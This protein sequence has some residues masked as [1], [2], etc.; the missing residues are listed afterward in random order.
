[1]SHGRTYLDWNATAPLCK[2]ARDAMLAAL[3][4]VGNAS[5]VHAEGRRARDLVETARDQVARLVGAAP[6]DV[7]FTSGATEANAT[8]LSGGWDTIFVSDAEHESVVASAKVSRARIVEIP[9]G[10]DGQ[11]EVE[12]IAAEIL[13]GAM[14]VGRGLISLQMANNET[15]VIQPVA[16]VAAFAHGHGLMTHTDAVQACGRIVVD[17][18]ALGVDY[19]AL[20]AHKLGGPKGVGAL[21]LR[22]GAA[23]PALLVG[24]GQE[25]RRRAGTENVAGIAGFGAAAEQALKNLALVERQRVLRDT[26]ERD[27]LRHTAGAVVIGTG[28]ARLANTSCIAVPGKAAETLVI[29]LDLAG[30]A[31]SAGSACSSGKVGTSPVLRAMG[32]AP[33]LARGAIR[34]SIGP[35]TTDQD[36]AR[37]LSAWDQIMRPAAQAA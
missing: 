18:A 3:D 37:F 11:F 1:M 34:I 6:A 19:L 4:Y 27:V 16:E 8:V 29:K 2:P 10:H 22:D 28:S 5:S 33:G 23:L 24:G 7:V 21:V 26:L 20:S 35:E 36:V 15:G 25:R 13:C 30:I 32:I 17:V 9:A 12:S 31:V 14:P